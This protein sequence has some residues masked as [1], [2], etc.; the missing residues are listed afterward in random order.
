ML[1]RS[2]FTPSPW[3]PSAGALQAI[4]NA[5]PSPIFL[6]DERHRLVL[7]NDCFC[8]LLGQPRDTLLGDTD[9]PYVP[10][11]QRDVFWKAD[12]Q[13]FRTGLPNEN[14]EVLTNG[15]GELRVVVTR[16]RLIHL[17]TSAGEEPFLIG[18]ISDVTRFR[19]AEGRAQ[20][21]AEHDALTG[22]A[23]R[24]Q[25]S[26]RLTVAVE[27]AKKS[28]TSAAVLMLDLD[29]F[30][31]I[32]DRHGHLIGDELLRVIAK[33]LASLVR[34]TDTVA[35]F[36]GD[37]FCIIQSGPQQP[38]ASFALA[39]RVLA[40]IAQPV[41][42]GSVR[43]SVSGSIGIACFPDDAATPDLL[44]QKADQA[45]YASK[46]AGRGRYLPYGGCPQTS[47]LP[48]WDVERDLRIALQD[49]QLWLAFQPLTAASDGK[50]RGFEAL[51][52]WHHPTRGEVF[53][54]EFIPVAERTGMIQE[55]GRYVL[56]MACRAAVEWPC[57]LMVSVNVS[58]LQLE[59]GDLPDVVVKALDS[60][61]L[62]AS[63]LELEI[64]ETALLGGSDQI[65]AAFKQ[66][67]SLG[68]SLALDDFGAG[69]SSLASLQ[70]FQFDR[71][72][73][74]R[75]FIANIESDPRS[76]AIV[77]AVLSLGHALDV[78]ITAEGIEAHAQ[79]VALRT[80][81]CTELQGYYIGRPHANPM[82]TDPTPW[83]AFRQ[84]DHQVSQA[85]NNCRASAVVEAPHACL[86]ADTRAKEAPPGRRTRRGL[87]VGELA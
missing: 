9:A 79:L 74:D 52:R 29:G 53:P 80:M 3:S 73:I 60:S 32:N 72:K 44:M 62:G 57:D 8:E 76:L 38:G 68:V 21:L 6:K 56:N 20:Y 5:V 65:A 24:S 15:T 48:G 23:N 66:I 13:V 27:Y 40:S 11:E 36:G 35:R 18:V 84:H 82:L 61:G 63:R 83:N 4:L 54:D 30:K 47:A 2:P 86:S 28:D 7:V 71:I 85:N 33:R 67:R 16:K 19:E 1:T 51:V 64:T 26:D 42:V 87:H 25:L 12:D 46:K 81:G 77:R 69:W 14:E 75:S 49:E 17:P 34:T 50:V 39:E 55:L 59:N 43:M 45:L 37:E 10:D 58:P 70:N 31:A 78:P 22:L 41:V